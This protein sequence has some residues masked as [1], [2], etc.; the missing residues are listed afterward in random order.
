M[1]ALWLADPRGDRWLNFNRD[2]CAQVPVITAFEAELA[3]TDRSETW[4]LSSYDFGFGSSAT[5]ETTAAGE[6][7][8]TPGDL[9]QVDKLELAARAEQAVAAAASGRGGEVVSAAEFL[10]LRRGFQAR[11]PV[12]RGRSFWR[13]S[14][15]IR[16]MSRD[17]TQLRAARTSA[18]RVLLK[19]APGALPCT[20]TSSNRE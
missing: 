4:D 12:M 15:P 16:C 6:L 5:T 9:V 11:A 1:R 14:P 17:W 8:I 18:L 13:L 2:V 7:A 10:K 3:F 19:A 20:R